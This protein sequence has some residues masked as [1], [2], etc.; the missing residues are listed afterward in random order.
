M[1]AVG[2]MCITVAYGRLFWCLFFFVLF[3]LPWIFVDECGLSLVAALWLWCAGFSLQW[4]LLLQSTSSRV[5]SSVVA[6]QGF[7]RPTVS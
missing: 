1:F 2:L 3:C 5:V 4:R 6:E 7:S